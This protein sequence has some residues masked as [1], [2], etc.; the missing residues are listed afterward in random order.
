MKSEIAEVKQMEDQ[1]RNS[2]KMTAY[3]DVSACGGCPA[4]ACLWL[5]CGS[6]V[7]CG[8]CCETKRWVMHRE[9]LPV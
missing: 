4:A 7:V 3:L 5:C 1:E 8:Y 9:L 6:W 2:K